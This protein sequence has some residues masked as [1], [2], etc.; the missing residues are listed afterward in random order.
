MKSSL[1]FDRTFQNVSK[2]HYPKQIA[3]LSS[4]ECNRS[5][6]TKLWIKMQEEVK[7]AVEI[8]MCVLHFET[9]EI[10]AERRLLPHTHKYNIVRFALKLC[11]L[12]PMQYLSVDETCVCGDAFHYSKMK[13]GL[14]RY[15]I[16][17]RCIEIQ[18]N[19][20]YPHPHIYELECSGFCVNF[21]WVV[22]AFDIRSVFARIVT[23]I[24]ITG[25][26]TQRMDGGKKSANSI[27]ILAFISCRWCSFSLSLCSF[28]MH[29]LHTVRA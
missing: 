19:I 12:N 21:N 17:Y 24:T 27:E 11:E 8:H 23:L 4:L 10:R 22:T 25:N 5:K 16:L 14:L 20:H 1:G 9:G 29:R 2:S 26:L 13:C 7:I 6:E 15:S 18:A 3:T 28:R